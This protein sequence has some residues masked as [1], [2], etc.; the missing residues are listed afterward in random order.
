MDAAMPAKC[1]LGGAG[2]ELVGREVRLTLQQLELLGRDDQVQDPLFCADGAVAFEQLGQIRAHAEAHPAAMAA[3]LIGLDHQ[4]GSG[5]KRKR[6]VSPVSWPAA[7]SI[8]CA[9]PR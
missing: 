7:V 6:S 8:A 4:S 1:V 9:W 5:T 3:A 2:V